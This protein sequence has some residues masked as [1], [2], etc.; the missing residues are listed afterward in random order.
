MF[1][2]SCLLISETGKFVL[3]LGP[4]RRELLLPCEENLMRAEE[5]VYARCR[6]AGLPVPRVLVC[7][8][9]K[10][11]LDRDFMLTEYI[12]GRTLLG[13]K[14]PRRAALH[15][16]VGGIV[17]QMHGI[18]G[19]RFGRAADVAQGSGYERWSACISAE[20]AAACAKAGAAGIYT[21]V[22]IE[23]IM[24]AVRAHAALLDEIAMP[25]LVHADLWAGNVL[26]RGRRVAAVI[27]A[28]RAIYG[29][30]EF[31]FAA[32][33]MTDK[34]FFRGYGKGLGR[35]AASTTRRGIY[36]MLY[37][38]LDS[39]VLTVE[40]DKPAD[41]MREKTRA[42]EQLARLSP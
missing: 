12:P 24:A 7:D 19:D 41:G 11:L 38:L 16:Q 27:D 25:Q 33:W 14:G 37:R 30:A 35:G 15:A 3:R 13:V 28:D 6:A 34:A 4:V 10:L 8:T 29:D 2:T 17:R 40:Y 22:E 9:T 39:Y 1:N 26:V 42:L 18:T 32:G 21:P 23:Q 31:E 20:F 36:A 5:Y